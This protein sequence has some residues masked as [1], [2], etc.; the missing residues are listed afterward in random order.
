MSIHDQLNDVHLDEGPL[1][2]TIS[3]RLSW[4]KFWMAHVGNVSK[5]IYGFTEVGFLDDQ[6]DVIMR[7][8][9]TTS[10]AHWSRKGG[11]NIE[12]TPFVFKDFKT[13]LTFSWVA[14]PIE[15]LTLL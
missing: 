3:H 15:Q 13:T 2:H 12:C 14:F 5:R 7:F 9:K 4:L 8:E 6:V 1:S 11:Q 10:M